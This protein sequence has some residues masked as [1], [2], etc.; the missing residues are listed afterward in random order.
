MEGM[1]L[2]SSAVGRAGRACLSLGLLVTDEINVWYWAP[3][4]KWKG[5]FCSSPVFWEIRLWFKD[6]LD[7]LRAGTK[8]ITTMPCLK[9]FWKSHMETYFYRSVIKYAQIFS[10]IFQLSIPELLWRRNPLGFCLYLNQ[11]PFTVGRSWAAC[12][13][14][15]KS[16]SVLSGSF[17]QVQICRVWCK[18]PLFCDALSPCC[19]SPQSFFSQNMKC[20]LLLLL[21]YRQNI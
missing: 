1:L 13:I 9:A 17:F 20:F 16:P 10:Y 4:Q 19:S 8:G 3:L 6:R 18:G 15:S 5:V 12:T 7:C 11:L 21:W 14:I 2:E